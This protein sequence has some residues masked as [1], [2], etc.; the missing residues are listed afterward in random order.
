M[1]FSWTSIMKTHRI[2]HQKRTKNIQKQ[3]VSK[4]KGTG[5]SFVWK[6]GTLKKLMVFHVFPTKIA[7]LGFFS[8]FSDWLRSLI[9]VAAEKRPGIFDTKLYWKTQPRPKNRKIFLMDS[10]F[11][12][13]FPLGKWQIISTL[14]I[15]SLGT[16]FL[17]CD[18]WHWETC[19]ESRRLHPTLTGCLV[20]ENW[21][22]VSPQG[23]PVHVFIPKF[24]FCSEPHL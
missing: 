2:F 17:S 21:V 3:Y 5:S 11:L 13:D 1:D 23:V 6:S 14:S 24:F 20:Q 12:V 19:D 15:S 7:S 18:F 9:Q 4:Q 16:R 8:Q 22:K 10:P